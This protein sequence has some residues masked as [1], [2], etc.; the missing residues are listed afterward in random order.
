MI[1]KSY[2]NII[3]FAKDNNLYNDICNDVGR[4]LEEYLDDYCDRNIIE[5]VMCDIDSITAE[6]FKYKI[7]PKWE[8]G[9]LNWQETAIKIF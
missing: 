6:K 7:F 9:C 2:K 3:E 1:K 5:L 8:D 4:N